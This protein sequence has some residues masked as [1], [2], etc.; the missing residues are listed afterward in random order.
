M[1]HTPGPWRKEYDNTGNGGYA[2]WY[3]ILGA[4]GEAIGRVFLAPF[5]ENITAKADTSLIIAA[6]DLLEAAIGIR[7]CDY[8]SLTA[9]EAAMDKLGA[10]IDKALGK[11]ATDERA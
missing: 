10:A 1:K 5:A 9:W 8:E 7:D 4:D 3:W 11:E 6:P 2:E